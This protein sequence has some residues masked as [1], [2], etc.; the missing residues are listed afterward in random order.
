MAEAMEYRFSPLIITVDGIAIKQII[1][2]WTD[3]PAVVSLT[4]PH[5][6]LQKQHMA[7]QDCNALVK[8][9]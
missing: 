9:Y 7:T 6:V 4:S 5:P 3:I 1:I 2:R 8:L